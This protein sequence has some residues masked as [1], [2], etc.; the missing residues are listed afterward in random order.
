MIERLVDGNYGYIWIESIRFLVKI[1]GLINIDVWVGFWIGYE[2]FYFCFFYE[3][4][5]MLVI[6]ESLFKEIGFVFKMINI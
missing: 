5:F 4:Y 2:F 6:L 3:N 1:V